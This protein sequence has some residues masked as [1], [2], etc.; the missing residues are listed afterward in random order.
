MSH[1][2]PLKL[3]GVK[4]VCTRI[5]FEV[6]YSDFMIANIKIQ[7]PDWPDINGKTMSFK[8][9]LF[10]KVNQPVYIQSASFDPKS[11]M[12]YGGTYLDAVLSYDIDFSK[13]SKDEIKKYLSFLTSETI[14]GEIVDTL[15]DPIGALD[16]RDIKQLT[17]VRGVGEHTAQRIIDQHNNNK[18]YSLALSVIPERYGITDNA[19]REIVDYYGGNNELAIEALDENTYCVVHM[20]GFGFKTAD[21]MFLKANENDPEKETDPRRVRAY[22][23]YMFDNYYMDGAAWMTDDELIHNLQS[24]IPG[25]NAQ[26]VADYLKD[27]EKFVI[28]PTKGENGKVSRISAKEYATAE[29]EIANELIERIAIEESK[30]YEGV[31]ETLAEVERN[32]GFQFDE[33]QR[34][35]I[36]KML[37]SK[38]FL[39]QGL[40][41]SGKSVV[42]GG[43]SHIF[44]K[45]QL[46]IGQVA[47]SGKA[48]SNLES[49]T[50][51]TGQ[52]I[53]RLLR[54]G[55][56]EPYNKRNKLP[57]DV[58]I[59][60]EISM[61]GNDIFLS[62][63]QAM[64]DDAKLI[65]VG[66]LGQLPSIGVGPAKGIV[67]SDVI[68]SMTLKNIHR[69]AKDSAIVT[70]SIS[71]RH[72]AKPEELTYENGS[73]GQSGDLK[74]LFVH[75]DA[76]PQIHSLSIE[77]FKQQLDEYSIND[78]SLIT[79]TRKFVYSLNTMA[80]KIANPFS[81]N[82]KEFIVNHSKDNEYTIRVGDKVINMKNNYNTENING[83]TQ[84]IFNGNTGVVLDILEEDKK[85][86]A[87]IDFDGVD[88]VRVP[89][90]KFGSPIELGYAITVH[91]A[92]GMTIKSVIVALPYQ[93]M[94]NTKEL[95]YTAITR[96]SKS[97][98]I[99]TSS[100]TLKATYK[101]SSDQ[102]QR[103]N[104]QLFLQY[105]EIMNKKYF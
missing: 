39:L 57:H 90:S 75:K 68:P 4:G 99:V 62:L 73:Y 8:G 100:R 67:N 85:A 64:K 23:D 35:A 86:I 105:N 94:L 58:I 15:D 10:L 79:S 25:F 96:A 34:L 42:I 80:Q 38:V 87:I 43:A 76:E 59:V 81:P 89:L 45:N 9:N 102:V 13:A 17:S 36:E 49:V 55:Q 47:L 82:K 84:P 53:H 50:G 44:A 88:T 48:A 83:E 30:E 103:S 78:I 6:K 66:D 98:Y 77:L 95:L 40:G 12:Q 11:D 3:E 93:Y 33:H 37:S 16:S 71:F 18:D 14:A 97:C 29:M 69:Q 46:R 24:N 2:L 28:I 74:Y 5:P 60:D 72:G 41:G 7:D 91:K 31:E 54:Y 27:K 1:G 26:Y 32:Q 65:M 92:Q 51:I 21:D 61:V 52:T 104:L 22:I 63:I 101:K 19:T 70:H 20:P 56:A